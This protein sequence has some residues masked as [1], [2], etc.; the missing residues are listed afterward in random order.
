MNGFVIIVQLILGFFHI[1]E[2]FELSSTDHQLREA[3]PQLAGTRR[4]TGGCLG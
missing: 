1:N 3:D 4:G 2:T